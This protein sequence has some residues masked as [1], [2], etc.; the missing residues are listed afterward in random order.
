MGI[1]PSCA[2]LA[3][4]TTSDAMC[5]VCRGC[6]RCAASAAPVR[7]MA[8]DHTFPLFHSQLRPRLAP[9]LGLQTHMGRQ[10]RGSRQLFSQADVAGCGLCR[11]VHLFLRFCSPIALI[12]RLWHLSRLRAWRLTPPAPRAPVV[13]MDVR[14]TGASFGSWTTP[15]SEA[16]QLDSME[17]LDWIGRQPFCDGR[18]SLF[19]VCSALLLR[20]TRLLV[21]SPPWLRGSLSQPPPPPLLPRIQLRLHIPR[22]L[23]SATAASPSSPPPPNPRQV[24]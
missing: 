12:C 15:W 23:C 6:L 17:L 3:P 20:R 10:A 4:R 16:E 18:V 1:L 5:P 19:G 22:T 21:C 13:C 24:G 7:P 8:S 9:A 11:H 14:G 2:R